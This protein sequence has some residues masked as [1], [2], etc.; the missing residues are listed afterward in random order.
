MRLPEF[1]GNIA[2]WA[3]RLVGQLN[4][5]FET[6]DSVALTYVALFRRRAVSTGITCAG[7][8]QADAAPLVRDL[9]EITTCAAGVDDAVR[10]YT[11]QA[12]MQMTV[13]NTTA[14]DAQ[15]FPASGETID[16]GATDAPFTLPAGKVAIFTCFADKAS[17][18]LLGA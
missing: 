14:D 5:E 12:G 4:R 7:T 6:R 11:M 15:V 9:N 18:S 16:G 10:L 2:D 1:S 13:V 17:R 3:P 8:T